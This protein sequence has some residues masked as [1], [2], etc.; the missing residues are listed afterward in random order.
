MS[1][2]L[3]A[4]L[5]GHRHFREG[6]LGIQSWQGSIALPHA[7]PVPSAS[8]ARVFVQIVGIRGSPAD[9]SSVARQSVVFFS[10]VRGFNAGVDQSTLPFPAVAPPWAPF[11]PLCQRADL[12]GFVGLYLQSCLN[13]DEWKSHSGCR[14]R[15]GS[16]GV[17]RHGGE[18]PCLHT[19]ECTGQS[20]V[21]DWQPVEHLFW[22][23]Q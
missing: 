23:A 15:W 4:S 7:M 5:S 21:S 16:Q 6:A 2:L 3:L 9:Y 10:S 14:A 11:L 17:K 8:S 22:F 18:G 20:D 19:D 1:Q 12:L 13:L